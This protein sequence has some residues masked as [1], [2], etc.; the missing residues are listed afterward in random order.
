MSTAPTYFAG[1][2]RDLWWHV[3]GRRTRVLRDGLLGSTWKAGPTEP[4][5]LRSYIIDDGLCHGVDGRI[6]PWA[7]ILLALALGVAAIGVGEAWTMPPR[8]SMID[9]EAG[10]MGGTASVAPLVAFQQFRP[11]RSTVLSATADHDLH[12]ARICRV[13]GVFRRTP[14]TTRR[15]HR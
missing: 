11:I 7:G 13:I 9:S 3:S 10:E 15:G 14:G 12:P 8:L 5:L 2:W 6:W 4:P 1:T